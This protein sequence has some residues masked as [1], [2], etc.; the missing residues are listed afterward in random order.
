[1]GSKAALPGWGGR[2]QQVLSSS[3]DPGA[4]SELELGRY[5]TLGQPKAPPAK[6][7]SR[8]CPQVL[9]GAFSGRCVKVPWPAGF[10]NSQHIATV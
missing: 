8:M 9:L 4:V 10:T 2:Q 3:K 6:E 1:M 5:H 7:Q